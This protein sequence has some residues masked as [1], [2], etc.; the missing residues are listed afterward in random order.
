MKNSFSNAVFLLSLLLTVMTCVS[1]SDEE[2]F[3]S[4]PSH[5]LTFSEDT[6]KF[7]T[8]FTT[9]GSSTQWLKVFNPNSDGVRLSNISL[10]SGGKSGFYMNVDGQSGTNFSNV[11]IAHKDSIFIF[12]EVNVDPTDEDSPVLIED[13][14]LFVHENGMKQYVNLIAY[15]QDVIIMDHVCFDTDTTLAASRPYLVYDSLVVAPGHTLTLSEGT[16]LYFH[17]RASLIVHGTLIS[18]GSL[19]RP[20]VMRGDRLDRMFDYLPYDRLDAQWGGVWLTKESTGN[21]INYTDIHSGSYGIR[22]EESGFDDYKLFMTNSTIHNVAGPGLCLNY[23]STYV[24][25]SQISNANTYCVDIFG[26]YARFEQCTIA[27]FY[28]WKEH[29]GAVRF[30]NMRNDTIADLHQAAFY[31]CYVTGS[32]EDEI[33]GENVNSS[34]YGEVLFNY[35]FENSVLATVIAEDDT[36]FVSCTI[37]T[38]EHHADNFRTIDTDNYIYDFRLDT[39]SVA[40]GKASDKFLTDYPTDRLGIQRQAGSVDA[41]CYQFQ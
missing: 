10:A 29:D 13:S 35:H 12:V 27:Q 37:D 23:C 7:D 8:V 11:E 25:N 19:E 24:A 5:P 17:S 9:I 38:L 15:G 2:K 33:F 4:S 16:S 3:T 18:N 34:N 40:R 30:Y 6:L 14:I 36:N 41:G 20:V 28:P 22:C 1:C 21:V 39:L 31:N 26:G 32:H